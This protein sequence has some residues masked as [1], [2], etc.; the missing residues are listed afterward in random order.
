[1]VSR[2]DPNTHNP[3]TL[4]VKFFEGLFGGVNFAELIGFCQRFSLTKFCVTWYV[5]HALNSDCIIILIIQYLS[6]ILCMWH[7]WW[8]F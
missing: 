6:L 7:I 8:W 4:L 2:H 5:L 3:F 1:M